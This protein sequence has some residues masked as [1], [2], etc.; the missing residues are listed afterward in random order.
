MIREHYCLQACYFIPWTHTEA[1]HPFIGLISKYPPEQLD[2]KA[3]PSA[4]CR[5]LLCCIYYCGVKIS[6]WVQYL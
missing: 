2:K 3:F 5:F 6:H 4:S 1:Y